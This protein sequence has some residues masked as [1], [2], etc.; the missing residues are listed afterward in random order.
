MIDRSVDLPAFFAHSDDETYR[1]GGTRA[2][3]A[4]S[5]ARIHLLMATGGQSGSCGHPPQARRFPGGL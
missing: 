4:L 5:G 1:P 3:L 2:L